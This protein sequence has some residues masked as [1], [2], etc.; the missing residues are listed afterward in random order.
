MISFSKTNKSSVML[1]SAHTKSQSCLRLTK[2]LVACG[3]EGIGSCGVGG[4]EVARVLEEAVLSSGVEGI[5]A[6][7]LERDLLRTP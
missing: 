3:G 7:V 2:V 5:M 1:G 6:G 4:A